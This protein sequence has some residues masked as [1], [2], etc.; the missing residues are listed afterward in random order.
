MTQALFSE[1]LGE[2]FSH[3]AI[4]CS[5]TLHTSGYDPALFCEMFC[6]KFN[7]LATSHSTALLSVMFCEVFS[8][9]ART[10][11]GV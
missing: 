5:I 6:E 10:L 2:K 9:L 4:S 7:R 1:T 3:L 11:N 8:L